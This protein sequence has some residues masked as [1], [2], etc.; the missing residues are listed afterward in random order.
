MKGEGWGVV[1]CCRLLGV[2]PFVLV[3]SWWVSDGPVNLYQV[4][5]IL[6]SD[7]NGQSSQGQRSFSK[8]PILAER[9]E[10]SAGSSF[11]ARLPHPAQPSSLSEPGIQPSW[12]LASPSHL[13]GETR[14][15]RLWTGQIDAAIRPRRQGRGE[16]HC[17]LMAWA[18]ASG[19]LSEVLEPFRTPVG[20]LGPLD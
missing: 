6:C 3:Q 10:I 14:S 16:D 5:F 19:G 17:G 11:K 12:P 15:H 13:N 1:S 2:R 20:S 7:T 4:Q 9:R 8:A 18:T